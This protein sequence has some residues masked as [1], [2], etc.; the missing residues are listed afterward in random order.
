MTTVLLI[1]LVVALG[2][3]MSARA[4]KWLVTISIALIVVTILGTLLFTAWV[5]ISSTSTTYVP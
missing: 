1:C 3:L 4:L 2:C 5:S